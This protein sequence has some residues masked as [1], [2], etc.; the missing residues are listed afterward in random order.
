[1]IAQQEEFNASV[2][3]LM[4]AEVGDLHHVQ[5]HGV[6]NLLN[7]WQGNYLGL[8]PSRLHQ[9]PMWCEYRIVL[10]ISEV[11]VIGIERCGSP[12]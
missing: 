4:L 9:V 3:L 12:N 6:C 11:D 2:N 5:D 1:M 7:P 10:S 8:L